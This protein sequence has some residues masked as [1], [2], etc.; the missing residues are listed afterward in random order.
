MIQR[1]Q[2][3]RLACMKASA[4]VSSSSRDT[5]PDIKVGSHDASAVPNDTKQLDVS[6]LSS[7]SSSV[8]A[9]S[10]VERLLASISDLLE[11]RLRADTERRH[12][13]DK[14]HQMVN[15]WMIAAAVIDRCCFIIFSITLIIGSFLFY[16]LTLY[17]S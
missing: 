14:N 3:R 17:R 16:L 7:P 8:A 1:C 12:Q 4:V 9:V 5:P 11:T 10:A 15:E 2:L 13:A 6:T